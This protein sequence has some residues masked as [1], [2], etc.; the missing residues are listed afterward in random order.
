MPLRCDMTFRK[1]FGKAWRARLAGPGSRAG[2]G[3]MHAVAH[4]WRHRPML[5]CA[6]HTPAETPA[7][8][9]PARPGASWA[10]MAAGRAITA[11]DFRQIRRRLL[12]CSRQC[13]SPALARRRSDRWAVPGLPRSTGRARQSSVPAATQNTASAERPRF[14]GGRP[15][16][17]WPGPAPGRGSSACHSASVIGAKARCIRPRGLGGLGARRPGA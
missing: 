12:A 4:L 6:L 7:S 16:R 1:Q 13:S 15:R 10:G 8:R 9:P 11:V 3:R 5:C 14:P 2:C 17:R